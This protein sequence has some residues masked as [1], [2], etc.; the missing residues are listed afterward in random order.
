MIPCGALWGWRATHGGRRAWEGEPGGAERPVLIAPHYP[1][2]SR[3]ESSLTIG[4]SEWRSFVVGFVLLYVLFVSMPLTRAVLID[5]SLTPSK[6]T[7]PLVDAQP[8]TK[9]IASL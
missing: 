9:P 2:G 6:P 1:Q 4:Q 7:A 5:S 3:S 8:S